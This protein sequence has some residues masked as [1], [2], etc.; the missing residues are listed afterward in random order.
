MTGCF[1]MS[2][3][4]D[5]FVTFESEHFRP[6]AIS[7]SG[8]RLFA[9]NTPDNRIEVYD[10][11]F[12]GLTHLHSVPV[13]MEPVAVSALSD[14]EIWVANHLSDSVSIV[15]TGTNPPRVTRTLLVGD[16]PRDVVFAS[17][18]AFITTAHRGQ[19]S[20]YTDPANP[21]EMMSEGI[22]RADVWVFDVNNQGDAMGGIPLTI[23]P[24][25]GDT[26]GPLAVSPDGSKVYAGVFKSGNQTTIIVSGVVCDGGS[27]AEPCAPAIGELEAPG[28]VPAPSENIEGIPVPSGDSGLIVKWD[29]EAWRDVIGRN[30]N[31]MV[32]F[33]LPDLDV[34][35]ID[36]TPPI[37][38]ETQSFASVGTILFSMAVNPANGRVFV[39]N[40]DA[41]NEARFEQN[42]QGRIHETRITIL[43]PANGSVRPRHLNKHIDYSIVPSPPDIKE[44]SLAYPKSI[45]I[46]ADGQTT[47]V[48]AKGS[49]KIG[50][51]ATRELQENT[52][53]PDSANHISVTG[54]GPSGVLVDP[55][56][57]QIYVL[58][59]FDNGISVINTD[60]NRE[61]WHVTMPNPEPEAVVAGRPLH[62]DAN[63]T[64]SNGEVSCASCH[65]GGDKDELAWDLGDPDGLVVLDPNP[66]IG[67]CPFGGCPS[68]FH[69][70]K[71]PMMT[72]TVRG[73]AGQ[74]P[75][76][77]RGDR[78]GG[79]DGAE[80]CN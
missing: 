73:L 66:R 17:G 53:E 23:L 44:H 49:G 80:K 2:F 30:W 25:F 1:S 24:L 40:T 18:K 36:A 38:V 72:Q 76:H 3:A 39:A 75:L 6:L 70:M 31:N 47:Y 62:Y 60:I 42:V 11:G 61:I 54:G 29:G 19:N 63:Y 64:S 33:D 22:G 74:G 37:P 16:E 41:R 59:R 8:D 58:T 12:F 68:R 35:E 55:N 52:F 77:W 20:P 28:G 78:S 48:A 51:F 50:V 27:D 32:R 79:F 56:R 15:D 13:G 43:N 5:S 57:D 45:A 21:M 26:P 14:S 65:I 67:G 9:V 69:P 10:I 71:G 4:N 34:F 7:P 46:S